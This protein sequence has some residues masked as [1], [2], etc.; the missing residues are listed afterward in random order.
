MEATDPEPAASSGGA[1]L[2]WGTDAAEP[3][4]LTGAT[5]P[6]GPTEPTDMP[7]AGETTPAGADGDTTLVAADGDTST[8]PA[9][10]TPASTTPGT[11]TDGSTAPGPSAASPTSRGPPSITAT[12]L[13]AGRPESACASGSAPPALAAARERPAPAGPD[14]G[15]DAVAGRDG[16]WPRRVTVEPAESASDTDAEDPADPVVSAAA[17]A[18]IHITAAPTPSAT[19]S[20]PTRPTDPAGPPESCG[21]CERGP[22]SMGRTRPPWDARRCALRNCLTT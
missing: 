18:G 20:A 6:T 2:S 22:Y 14:A 4:E 17:T 8:T 16:R 11:T 21:A 7:A 5:E 1:A 13:R 19:A 9:S 10:T 3:A 15:P 12:L